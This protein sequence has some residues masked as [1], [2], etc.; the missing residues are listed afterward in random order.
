MAFSHL[1]ILAFLVSLIVCTVIMVTK[2][3]HLHRTAKG[4]GHQ[5]VQ[6]AHKNPT[7][8]IGGL[9]VLIAFAIT[10]CFFDPSFGQTALFLQVAML[11]VFIGGLGEDTGFDITPKIRLFLSLVSAL[12]AGLLLDQWVSRIGIPGLDLIVATTFTAAII[13][14]V[15]AGGFSHAFNLIDGL[16]GL[17]LGVAIMMAISLCIIGFMKNDDMIMIMAGVLAASSFG[18]FVFNFPLGKLFL[19]DAG[20]YS[21][22]HLLMWLA[23]MLINRHADIAPF[24]LLLI[25]F[26]PIADMLLS[27]Y[28]RFYTGKPISAPDR[29][30][31]HQLMMRGLEI[32]II[33]RKRRHLANPIA[34]LMI[35]PLASMPMI[36]GVLS[37]NSDKRAAVAFIMAIILFV[38]AYRVGG[39]AAKRFASNHSVS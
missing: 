24:A 18:L 29:L 3:Y 7:S 9:A 20:A 25:F 11:P 34:T 15:I 21:I 10:S 33:G 37:Y 26:W 1:V 16:N 14:I 32:T 5:A 22:G 12:V 8:R 30:H 35:L 19:G 27:I 38:L 4:H 39:W 23:V 13:T 17:A 2:P 31:F 36:L 28:R 6:S